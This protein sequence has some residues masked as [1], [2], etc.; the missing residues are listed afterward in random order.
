LPEIL[1]TD[2]RYLWVKRVKIVKN[3]GYLPADSP[4]DSPEPPPCPPLKP[5]FILQEAV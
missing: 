5:H 2:L 1:A 4:A 3:E